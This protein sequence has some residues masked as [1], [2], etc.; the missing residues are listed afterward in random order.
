MK[1]LWYLK[2]DL[3]CETS[4]EFSAGIFDEFSGEASV[5]DRSKKNQH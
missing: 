1:L 4:T 3:P 2:I 5:C